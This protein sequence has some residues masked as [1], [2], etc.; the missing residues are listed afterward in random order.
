MCNVI[1]N[2]NTAP[3]NR[4]ECTCI[5]LYVRNFNYYDRN[6]DFLIIIINDCKSNT[7]G[8]VLHYRFLQRSIDIL[9]H[10]DRM[11]KN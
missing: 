9:W 1:M 7:R 2:S 11:S 5:R 6:S 10:V 3:L 8:I 4:I